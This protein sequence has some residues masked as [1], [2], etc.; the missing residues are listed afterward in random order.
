MAG[1]IIGPEPRVNRLTDDL[2]DG[3]YAA[4]LRSG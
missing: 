4:L 2:T 3:E 1:R